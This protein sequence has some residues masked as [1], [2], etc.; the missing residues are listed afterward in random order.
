MT[1]SGSHSVVFGRVDGFNCS[2]GSKGS[3][4]GL[5]AIRARVRVHPQLDRLSART[6]RP[7]RS[8]PGA[9]AQRR[10][11]ART[12]EW[13]SRSCC[14]RTAHPAPP[15][16]RR[17]ASKTFTAAGIM[18]LHEREKIRLDDRLGAYVGGLTPEVSKVTLAQL[19][20]HAAGLTRDGPN[21]GQF[22]D[23]RPFLSEAEIRADLAAPQPLAAGATFK[24]SESR[25]RAARQSHR[26]GCRRTLPPMD[27]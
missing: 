23:R 18:L 25:F 13:F 7:A 15:L 21:G 27:T 17:L 2:T 4:V 22:A 5:A 6:L 3:H 10:G 11:R 20:S 14:G 19:L 9:R 16:S 24:Y 1:S 8:R 26:K 12:R